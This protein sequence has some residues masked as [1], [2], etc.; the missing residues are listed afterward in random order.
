LKKEAEDL[1]VEFE[2]NANVQHLTSEQPHTIRLSAQDKGQK[3]DAVIACT[4]LASAELLKPLGIKIPLM[5]VHG[6]SI[7]ACST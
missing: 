3:F 4:G 5:A 1:G 2:L 7:S 6:Y